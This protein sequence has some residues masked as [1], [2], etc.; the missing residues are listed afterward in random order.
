MSRRSKF[1]RRKRET[2]VFSKTHSLLSVF[3]HHQK[4]IKHDKRFY[5]PS[6]REIR[7]FRDTYKDRYP[8]IDK[9]IGKEIR[10]DSLRPD[11][12]EYNL[13]KSVVCYRR[14]LKRNILFATKQVGKGKGVSPI[15]RFT[16][17][18]KI[19]CRRK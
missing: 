9:N 17:D 4:D 8:V 13:R 14:K 12:V 2:S 18:S 5:N 6:R 15:R 19:N 1:N 3:N 11:P 16:E 10:Q 7:P